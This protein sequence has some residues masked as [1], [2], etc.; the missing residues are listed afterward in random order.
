M[1]KTVNPTHVLV[2]LCLLDLATT[3]WVLAFHSGAEG[4]PLMARVLA[5]GVGMF[6]IAKLAL[7]FIPVSVL[8]WARRRRPVFVYRSSW[9]AVAAYILIYFSGSVR[10]NSGQTLAA[11]GPILREDLVLGRSEM[12][13]STPMPRG[14][15]LQKLLDRGSVR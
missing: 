7:V 12:L 11:S 5:Y 9:I 6:V 10:A 1:K 14:I 8:V 3:L 4:N 13:A 2:G 15:E